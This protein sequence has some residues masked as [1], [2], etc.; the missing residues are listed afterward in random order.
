MGGAFG[1]D[2]GAV[3]QV[4]AAVGADTSLLAEVLPAI[5]LAILAGLD[6]EDDGVDN[7]ADIAAD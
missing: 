6:D 3:M 4:G 2:M 7:E 5:E 1:L